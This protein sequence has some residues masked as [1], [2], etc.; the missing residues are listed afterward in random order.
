MILVDFRFH[1]QGE[2]INFYVEGMNKIFHSIQNDKLYCWYFFFISLAR[3]QFM[4]FL[5]IFLLDS[6][7]WSDIEQDT[8]EMLR[9]LNKNVLDFLQ[10]IFSLFFISF[11][12]Y[13]LFNFIQH[14]RWGKNSLNINEQRP[15][16]TARKIWR[17]PS[18]FLIF[19]NT[20]IFVSSFVFYVYEINFHLLS[21]ACH[22][23]FPSFLLLLSSILRILFSAPWTASSFSIIIVCDN[24]FFCCNRRKKF[25]LSVESYRTLNSLPRPRYRVSAVFRVNS[26]NMQNTGIIFTSQLA[27]WTPWMKMENDKRISIPPTIGK[28]EAR[29]EH[30]KNMTN[31]SH[32]FSRLPPTYYKL[33]NE[34]MKWR[35]KKA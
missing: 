14:F 2:K 8:D 22:K 34:I 12:E 4:I 9:N 21:F 15:G 27:I 29:K 20:K 16:P 32:S 19:H 26:E 13:R 10:R 1:Q 7:S 30:L 25:A 24:F 17:F 31:D 33:K 3:L 5:W 23:M 35:V 18:I 6:L 11:N 28:K